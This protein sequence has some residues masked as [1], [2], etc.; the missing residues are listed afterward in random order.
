MLRAHTWEPASMTATTSAQAMA[1]KTD[2]MGPSVD[3][4]RRVL[5][6]AVRSQRDLY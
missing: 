5:V 2:S 6:H 1:K 3:V 4:K